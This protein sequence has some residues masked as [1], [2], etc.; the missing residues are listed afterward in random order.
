MKASTTSV[1]FA[2]LASSG[3]AER[4]IMPNAESLAATEAPLAVSMED[5]KTLK[6]AQR[7]QDVADGVFGLNRYSLQAATSCSGGMAGEYSCN[8][9]D[10]MGF[11]RHQ[12]LGS[13]TRTGNDVWGKFIFSVF[14]LIFLSETWMLTNS[15]VLKAGRLPQDESSALLAKLT[16]L[17]SSKS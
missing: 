4:L 10:L 17:L 1:I 3:M 11:L 14:V 2:M 6:V 8:N 15:F 12:D 9:I 7:D 16:V 13:T 5:L